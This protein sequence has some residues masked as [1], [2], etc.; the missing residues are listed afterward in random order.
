MRL[1]VSDLDGTLIDAR[2]YSFHQAQPA[3]TALREGGVPL[4]LC[5]SKT[6]AEVELWRERLEIN[7]PFIVENGGALYIPRGYFP[8]EIDTTVR[9]DGYDVIEFGAPYS[10]LV[11]CLRHASE[12]AGCKVFGFSDMSVAEIC[13]RTFLPIRQAEFAKK[14]EYD[15]PFEMVGSNIGGLLAAIEAQGKRWTRGNRFYHITGA[16]DKRL[17]VQCVTNLFRRAAGHVHVIGAGDGH[18]DAGFLKCVDTP[19][20][21]RSPFAVALK[22]A[23]PKALVTRVSGPP[24]WNE[25]ILSVLRQSPV[26]EAA[27]SLPLAG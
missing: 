24:G 16:N 13:L 4:I 10:E 18:N 14:R 19:V 23:V 12:V 7:H 2:T 1:L 27:G 3:L 5:T 17:A 22:V 6:R 21:V 8:F 26:A 15:E 25:A 20:I 9:R 11:Q